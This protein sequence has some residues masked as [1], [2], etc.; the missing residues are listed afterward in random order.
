[1]P[2]APRRSWEDVKAD[3]RAKKAAA[4]RGTGVDPRRRAD[5]PA[6]PRPRREADQA[7]RDGR[8][9]LAGCRRRSLPRSQEELAE[10]EAAAR[11]RRGSDRTRRSATCCLRSPT[12]RGISG[13][14][15]K[16]RCATPTSNSRGASTM[17]RT[18]PRG[19]RSARRR[20]ARAAR[21]LLE[22]ESRRR[23]QE[24]SRLARLDAV[25]HEALRSKAALWRGSTRTS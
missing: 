10:A 1:M 6:R 19:W 13:S 24:R 23:R 16:P 7:R 21:R 18:A 12:S 5:G 17:S 2:A 22:R 20:R 15:P 11:R 4:R 9:R 14:I 3:E 25:P 8:L